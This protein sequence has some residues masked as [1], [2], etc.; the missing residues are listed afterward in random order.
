PSN[1]WLYAITPSPPPKPP[2]VTMP[3]H[4]TR[5]GAGSATS[6]ATQAGV[7]LRLSML[8]QY[9]YASTFLQ[10][11]QVIDLNQALAEYQQVYTANPSQ[12]GEA[13]STDGD[14]FG[15]DT[16]INTIPLPILV[17]PNILAT[18]TEFDL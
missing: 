13:V 18:A 1:I 14:G 8:D 6:S 10:G 2:G 11:L 16:I 7:A 12:F 5:V 9:L 4:V 3:P 15:M 17:P